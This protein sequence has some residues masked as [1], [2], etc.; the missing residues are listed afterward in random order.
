MF[1]LQLLYWQHRQGQASGSLDSGR[2]SSG[3]RCA[4]TC[5]F[6]LPGLYMGYQGRQ[7]CSLRIVLQTK[8]RQPGNYT[9]C[10]FN[11]ILQ[12]YTGHNTLYPSATSTQ[13]PIVH[14]PRC[15]NYTRINIPGVTAAQL[16]LQ[17]KLA[18]LASVK[19][20]TS[21][22]FVKVM[23][24]GGRLYPHVLS[25]RSVPSPSLIVT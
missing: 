3:R 24:V 15:R 10:Y 5:M 13:I 2:S 21:A 14:I 9:Q 22:M 19:K 18:P 6:Q 7:G 25:I 17:P 20:K 4:R 12:Y 1:G 16:R 11:S 8:L 23:M